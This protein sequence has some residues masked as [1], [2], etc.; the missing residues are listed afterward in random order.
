[1]KSQ[2]ENQQELKSDDH[3]EIEKKLAEVEQ[4]LETTDRQATQSST[5]TESANIDL[6]FRTCLLNNISDGVIFV[7][8]GLEITNWNKSA[9]AITGLGS[10][11][12]LGMKFSPDLIGLK[13]RDGEANGGAKC[14]VAQTLISRQP[15]NLE[16]DLV[17][18]SGREA[19][20]EL[21]VT[22][23]L[24][25]NECLGC[26]VLIRDLTA[27]ADLKRQISFLRNAN[28]MDP[29]THVANRAE[30]ER[31]MRE[32]VNAHLVTDSKCSLIVCDIDFFKKINEKLVK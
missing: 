17:G 21:S 12:I 20:I 11:N 3:Y 4:M 1:M 18:R 26:V 16:Y 14:P 27:S 22:P 13:T 25:L 6:L 10:S 32:Y 30:F 7:N 19:K 9:E 2:A 15:S 24:G 5:A 8:Q 31:S 29:L 28:T 23:V